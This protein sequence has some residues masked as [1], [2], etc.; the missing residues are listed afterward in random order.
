[1][2]RPQDVIFDLQLELYRLSKELGRYPA[3]SAYLT[4]LRDHAKQ[5]LRGAEE[6]QSNA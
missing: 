5:L 6:E 1:M 4:R 2:D 3:G